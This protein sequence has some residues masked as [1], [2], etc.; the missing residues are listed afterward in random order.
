MFSVKFC[1]CLYN[2]RECTSQCASLEGTVEILNV[3]LLY[4][5]MKLHRKCFRKYP[6]L[7]QTSQRI[8]N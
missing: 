2:V 5:H 7:F 3:K 6:V 4:D 1:E 8:I